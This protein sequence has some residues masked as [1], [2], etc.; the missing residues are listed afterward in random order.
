[1]INAALGCAQL[2]QLDSFIESK[3][4]LAKNY[5]ALLANTSLQFI[6]EPE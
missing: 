6:S 1:M 4:L 5:A 3:R 2:E